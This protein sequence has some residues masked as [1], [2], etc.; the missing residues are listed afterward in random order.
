MTQDQAD[1]LM[2]LINATD[3]LL[4]YDETLSGIISEEAQAYFSGQKT[5]EG[6]GKPG[7][8]PR[9]HLHK[10]TKIVS[11]VTPPGDASS[12]RG[13]AAPRGHTQSLLHKKS[14]AEVG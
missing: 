2:A 11:G 5:A 3:R 1:K 7:S 9:Q 8:E 6:R 4:T 12:F 14:Y 10:R 13:G